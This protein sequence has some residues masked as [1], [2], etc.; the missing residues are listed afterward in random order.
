MY[1]SPPDK[2]FKVQASGEVLAETSHNRPL[3]E[4]LYFVTLDV[5]EAEIATSKA[6]VES[7]V[8]NAFEGAISKIQN[9]V[10]KGNFSF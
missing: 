5:G 1:I 2:S 9:E 6:D 4:A 10:N 3:E 7:V 8:I